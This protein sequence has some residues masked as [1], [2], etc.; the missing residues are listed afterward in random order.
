MGR[1][2]SGGLRSRSGSGAQIGKERC[3]RSERSIDDE[4]PNPN[5]SLEDAEAKDLAALLLFASAGFGSPDGGPEERMKTE[6]EQKGRLIGD[7]R[8]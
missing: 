4:D 8:N 3:R 1:G 6:R 5:R 2:R 7:L